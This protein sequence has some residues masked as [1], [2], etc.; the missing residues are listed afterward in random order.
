M[1][2]TKDHSIICR[3]RRIM[4][5]IFCAVFIAGMVNM[6][7]FEEAYAE[8]AEVPGAPHVT[9]RI[10]GDNVRF[11]IEPSAEGGETKGFY[12]YRM[13]NGT[14]NTEPW[15]NYEN[16]GEEGVDWDQDP[17]GRFI[18]LDPAYHE[19]ATELIN[20]ADKLID[21]EPEYSENRCYL[22]MAKAWYYTQVSPN[23]KRTKEY[24]E[25]AAEI[26]AK[27][28]P[29]DLEIIDNNYQSYRELGGN[30]KI[31]KLYDEAR[32]IPTTE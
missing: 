4:L 17:G 24:S 13:D 22:C 6:L 28:F 7:P 9:C 19:D 30:G 3:I 15:R 11:F 2:F 21:N 5:I 16:E 23:P 12:I 1:R 32:E 27:V 20:M 10:I 18:R 31:H 29:T 14:P 8:G 25:K 26:A